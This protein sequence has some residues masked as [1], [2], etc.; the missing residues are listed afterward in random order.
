[1][2]KTGLGKDPL[3]WI[4]STIITDKESEEEKKE[5]IIAVKK[6]VVKIPKF[7][8][9]EV[10]LT[11]L[12]REDQL[13]FLEKLIRDIHKNREPQYRKERITKNT[14]IRVFIDAFRNVKFDIKNIP[15]EE[16]L[17]ERVL[18]KVIRD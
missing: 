7:Q 14:L 17:L 3:S 4:N 1:M 18:E 12:L 5:E 15:D 6:D 11:T 16:T 2:R 9:F 13:E 8:T 10:R